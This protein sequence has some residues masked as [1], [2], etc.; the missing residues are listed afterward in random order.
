MDDTTRTPSASR[1]RKRMLKNYRHL[2]TDFRSVGKFFSDYRK[3]VAA[4]MLE[5]PHAWG[6]G[7]NDLAHR[8]LHMR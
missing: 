4:A 6:T 8:G 5:G 3:K 2:Q 1:T 7:R